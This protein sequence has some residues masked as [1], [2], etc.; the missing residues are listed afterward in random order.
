MKFVLAITTNNI[1]NLKNCIETWFKTRSPAH[2]KL[3]IASNEPI[4]TTEYIQSLNQDC[5][6]IYKKGIDNQ[7]NAIIKAL[8]SIEFDVCFKTYDTI[9]F[10]RP[11]WDMLYYKSINETGYE[12]LVYEYKKPNQLN[13]KSLSTNTNILNVLGC[14]FTITPNVVKNVGYFDA[15]RYGLDNVGHIDYTYRCAMSGYN[16]RLNV[17]DIANSNDYIKCTNNMISNSSLFKNDIIKSNRTIYIGE[18]YN[19]NSDYEFVL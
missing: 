3:I 8:E 11:N 9:S 13:Y 14:F 1:N 7:T 6:T 5:I 16:N 12:H 10:I 15:E 19:C 2:W 4:G 17:Y 18:N